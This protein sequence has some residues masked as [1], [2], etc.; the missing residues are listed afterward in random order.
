[1]DF[2]R[3]DT[4]MN[5]KEDQLIKRKNLL[6]VLYPYFLICTIL[7]AFK[8]RKFEDANDDL[9]LPTAKQNHFTPCSCT[10]CTP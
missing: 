9:G 1:M 3:L 5:K 7:W 6:L 8:V 4:Q 10:H 2:P